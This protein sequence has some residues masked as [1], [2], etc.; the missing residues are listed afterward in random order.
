MDPYSPTNFESP[1]LTT[2][3]ANSGWLPSFHWSTWLVLVFV[4]AFFGF[5]IFVY[6]AKGTQTITDVFAPLLKTLFGTTLAATGQA[7]DVSAEG[8]KVVVGTTANAIEQGLTAIQDLTPNGAKATSSI[9]SP[10][11]AQAPSQAQAPRQLPPPQQPVNDDF[12]AYDASS[13]VHSAGK[14]GWCYIGQDHG[15][16]SCAQVGVNDTCMSGDIFPTQE[17]C[18]NPN[19]RV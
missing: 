12:Q 13:S 15:F 8:A 9:K 10:G 1:S 6:L 17:I 4:L 18:M 3:N 14:A 11:Q 7:V 16:R 2:S 5:N 19:L